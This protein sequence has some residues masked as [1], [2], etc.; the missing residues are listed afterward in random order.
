M[1]RFFPALFLLT[2]SLF[3]LDYSPSGEL[4][5]ICGAGLPWTEENSGRFLAGNLC[6]GG[7]LKVYG[8][9]TSAYIEGKMTFDSLKARSAASRFDFVTGDNS[10]QFSLKEGWMD[11]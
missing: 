9:N 5:A 7:S 4:S 1:K 2:S 3:A 11:Y 8:E 6:A 10:L